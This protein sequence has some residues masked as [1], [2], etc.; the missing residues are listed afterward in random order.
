M[1]AGISPIKP[2]YDT[3]PSFFDS[4]KN[5]ENILKKKYAP[6]QRITNF[7]ELVRLSDLETREKPQSKMREYR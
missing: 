1:P 2:I 6:E 5:I 7:S 4:K 3:F